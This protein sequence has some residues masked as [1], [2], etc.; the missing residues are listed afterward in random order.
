MSNEYKWVCNACKETFIS[1]IKVTNCKYCN[2]TKIHPYSIR[3][4]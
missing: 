4:L 1:T 3:I 2:S